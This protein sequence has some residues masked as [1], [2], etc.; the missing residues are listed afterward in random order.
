MAQDTITVEAS[1]QGLKQLPIVFYWNC[2]L[3]HTSGKHYI[4]RNC[5]CR[6][7]FFFIIH[8]PYDGQRQSF[9]RERAY[10]RMHRPVLFMFERMERPRSC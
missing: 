10:F 2:P 7:H 1:A 3:L 5:Q 8:K 6:Y 4:Q 9:L